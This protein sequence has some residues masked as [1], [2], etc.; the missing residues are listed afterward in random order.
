MITETAPLNKWPLNDLITLKAS[1]TVLQD[2]VS[3]KKFVDFY[4]KV[5]PAI[6]AAIKDQQHEL[7]QLPFGYENV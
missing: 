4:A 1:M 6:D 2:Y 3:D 7:T 5:L